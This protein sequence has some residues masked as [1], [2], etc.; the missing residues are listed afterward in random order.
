MKTIN[1]GQSLFE[2]V[3]AIAISALIIVAIVSLTTNSIQNSSY[4]KNKT[5]AATY[6]QQAS[7]WT[8]GQ[9]D[10]DM[11]TFVSHVI[12]PTWCLQDLS[13]NSPG[14]CG[15]N[16][17]ITGTQFIRQATFGVT[18]ENGKNFIESNI[19]VSWQDSK[20]I[21][22]VSSSTNLSDWRQR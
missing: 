12:T 14:G 1:S 13:W 8:R 21:H 15:E 18:T 2:V 9:R 5:L 7:E 4:S 17:F 10:S 16:S 20:G 11:N 22:Q 6:V 19:T 3:V